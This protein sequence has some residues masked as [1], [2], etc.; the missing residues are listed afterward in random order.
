MKVQSLNIVLAVLAVLMVV[1]LLG[2]YFGLHLI[3]HRAKDTPRIDDEREPPAKRHPADR[4]AVSRR[5]Q[6]SEPP[7]LDEI[8][9]MLK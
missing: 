1:V 8:E 2:P 6:G 4:S 7:Q 3:T 9:S 5:K